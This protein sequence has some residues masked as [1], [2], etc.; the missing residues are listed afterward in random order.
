MDPAFVLSA[1][2]PRTGVGLSDA[3]QRM[4][5]LR[6]TIQR[7]L[8]GGFALFVRD[9]F[10]NLSPKQVVDPTALRWYAA[11]ALENGVRVCELQV[12]APASDGPVDLLVNRYAELRTDSMPCVAG[13]KAIA[14]E[15]RGQLNSILKGKLKIRRR[16]DM[17]DVIINHTE[18][19]G[20]HVAY[21]LP[22]ETWPHV[23]IVAG[24][25]SDLPNGCHDL[26]FDEQ[27][28]EFLA[29]ENLP[30]TSVT[31]DNFWDWNPEVTVDHEAILDLREGSPPQMI[32]TGLVAKNN[33]PTAPF[34]DYGQ[35]SVNDTL[36]QH[37]ESVSGLIAQTR[38]AIPQ[39]ELLYGFGLKSLIRGLQ[40]AAITMAALWP[41]IVQ[42]IKREGS[43]LAMPMSLVDGLVV[44]VQRTK[45][46]VAITVDTGEKRIVMRYLPTLQLAVAVGQRITKKDNVG[47]YAPIIENETA[48]MRAYDPQALKRVATTFV[49]GRAVTSGGMAYA[50]STYCYSLLQYASKTDNRFSVR[51]PAW[52]FS[53]AKSDGKI[54]VFPVCPGRLLSPGQTV[55]LG[56]LV[57]SNASQIRVGKRLA[58][59]RASYNKRRRKPMKN[60]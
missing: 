5:M 44:N 32:A 52:A 12:E 59:A 20:D 8:E 16:G 29:D 25:C 23:K 26:L 31:G 51:L 7:Q 57:L 39:F 19:A 49:V 58:F 34:G 33:K 4:V 60:R 3:E 2:C 9:R 46:C 40:S 50:P 54:T 43:K 14:F 41:D 53:D 22:R 11:E 37:L 36:L 28:G 17:V 10:D 21:R 30:G 48:A 38:P 13:Q 15:L 47:V 45:T 1:G 42:E 55:S 35:V 56:D 24:R 27:K 18:N 6:E